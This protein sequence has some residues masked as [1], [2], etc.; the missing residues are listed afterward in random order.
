M[1][2]IPLSPIVWSKMASTGR[3]QWHVPREL[4]LNL[5]HKPNPHQAKTPTPLPT[6]RANPSNSGS[7]WISPG[8]PLNE[9]K[10]GAINRAMLKS[11]KGIPAF[12]IGLIPFHVA[13]LA[14]LCSSQMWTLWNTTWTWKSLGLA[15][16]A[17]SFQHVWHIPHKKLA[18]RSTQSHGYT[19]YSWLPMY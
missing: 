9:V 5:S 18:T 1:W 15:C 10:A 3:P 16:L 14:H 17:K 12:F 6:I 4:Q 19:L 7:M 2:R 8:M 13:P 11:Q